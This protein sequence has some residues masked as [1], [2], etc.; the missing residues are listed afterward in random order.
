MKKVIGLYAGIVACFVLYHQLVQIKTPAIMTIDVPLIAQFTPILILEMTLPCFAMALGYGIF[1]KFHD[2]RL[3]PWTL[4]RIFIYLAISIAIGS[5]QLLHYHFDH[6]GRFTL[7][8]YWD[9]PH[10]QAATSP[11]GE[12]C[13]L[14][15]CRTIG[16]VLWAPLGAIVGLGLAEGINVKYRQA[17]TTPHSR[18]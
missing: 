14:L 5:L 13:Q 6:A 8:S 10:N 12:F 16:V 7:S 17:S 9:I 2:L 4:N 18:R 3:T 1:T 11:V 15:F